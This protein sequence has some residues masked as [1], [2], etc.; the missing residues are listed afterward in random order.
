MLYRVRCF[1]SNGVVVYDKWELTR[2]EAVHIYWLR[3]D[4]KVQLLANRKQLIAER[5]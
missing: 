1:D 4:S 3:S 2:R 5:S